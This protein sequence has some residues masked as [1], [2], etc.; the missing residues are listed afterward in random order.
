M[1]IIQPIYKDKLVCSNYRAIK[2]LNVPYKILSGILYN[3]LTEYAEEILGEYQSRYRVNRSTID[4]IFTIRQTQEKVYE[5]NIHLHNL[6]TDFKKAFECVNRSRMSNDL[7]I[8]GIP[9]KLVQLIGV[10]VARSKAT[11]TVDNQYTSMFPIN[12]GARQGHALSS[13]LFDLVLEAILQ[14]MNITGHIGTKSTQIL[15]YADDV[16]I[17]SRSENAF[18]DTLFNTEKEAR[19]RGLLVNENKTKYMHVAKAVLNDE[20][21]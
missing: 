15:A 4:H 7:L 14:K 3:R 21:L 20:H 2:L 16:A 18:K 5:Y 1:G 9:K 13:I 6:F 17:M 8:L 19:G 10:T 11:I 12:N